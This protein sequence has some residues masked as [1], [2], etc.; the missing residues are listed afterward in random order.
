MAHKIFGQC[1]PWIESVKFS[2]QLFQSLTKR[3][4]SLMSS[5]I[6]LSVCL[7]IFWQKNV[8]MTE[9]ES[10]NNVG[11]LKVDGLKILSLGQFGSERLCACC[12]ICVLWNDLLLTCS[13]PGQICVYALYKEK[14][15]VQ[16]KSKFFTEIF[17]VSS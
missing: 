12:N 5:W 8:N 2:Y 10:L 11:A 13:T 1:L 15:W 16:N 14:T 9:I 17:L 6:C 7:S 4:L 3:T